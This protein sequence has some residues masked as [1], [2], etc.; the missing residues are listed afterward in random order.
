MATSNKVEDAR[1][2]NSVTSLTQHI[3]MKNEEL[4]NCP[5]TAV[6][7]NCDLSVQWNNILGGKIK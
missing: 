6:Q 3:I 2:Y 4:I 1:A 7:I 5:S